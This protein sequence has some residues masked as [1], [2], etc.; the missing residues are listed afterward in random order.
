MRG[1]SRTREH[2]PHG[3]ALW[4]DSQLGAGGSPVRPAATAHVAGDPDGVGL[5]GRPAGSRGGARVARGRRARRVVARAPERDRAARAGRPAPAVHG[6]DRLPR[7]IL[8]VDAALLLADRRRVP[9]LDAGGGL[10]RRAARGAGDRG[11]RHAAPGHR[12][13][14]RR[15][16]VHATRHA[17]D[18][19][20]PGHRGPH[21]CAGD[22]LPRDRRPR[23]AGPAPGDARRQRAD[24]GAL[25]RRAAATTSPSGRPTSPRRPVPARRG[26]CSAPTRTSRPSAGWR[27][28]PRR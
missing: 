24:D 7:W 3:T 27:R 22:H 14:R 1:H 17:P 21:G 25:D 2:R 20:P 13:H 6:R 19:A 23:T 26:S 10:R 9:G 8:A 28:R 18:R 11:G 16:R 5:R 12:R 4:R 15:R